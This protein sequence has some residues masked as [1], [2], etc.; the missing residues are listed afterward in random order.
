MQIGKTSCEAALQLW[1]EGVL[2]VPGFGEALEMV[3]SRAE[4]WRVGLT[5]NHV[6]LQGFINEMKGSD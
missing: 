5:S 4:T 6:R 2:L 1:R 3:G